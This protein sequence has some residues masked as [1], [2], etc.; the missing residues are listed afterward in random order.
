MQR[1]ND[2]VFPYPSP[3]RLYLSKLESPPATVLEH[4]IGHFPQVSAETWR[5]RSARGA[6]TSD[7]GDCITEYT[8]YRHGMTIFYRKE[9]ASEPEPFQEEII[10]YQD[11]EILVADKPHG[12]VVTPAGDHVERSLLVRLQRRTGLNTLVPAHRLDCETAGLVLLSVNPDTRAQYHA[13]FADGSIEREYRAVAYLDPLPEKREWQVRNRIEAGEPWFR[14]RVVDGP[15]N[16][17]SLVELIEAGQGIGL[18]RI[19]PKSGKKHQIR[20]HMTSIGFPIVGDRLYPEIREGNDID[21][22]LQLLA[23]QLEFSDPLNGESRN[24]QSVRAL[25]WR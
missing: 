8:P 25:V 6:I 1:P 18:F 14:K 2:S 20:V 3:S 19:R 15:P 22:P 9:V 4:L 10:L 16:T 5:S 7:H 23:H 17:L 21:L 12:M 24:F 11:G 13:L